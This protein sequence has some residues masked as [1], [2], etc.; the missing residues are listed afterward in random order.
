MKRNI[1]HIE[2]VIGL[3]ILLLTANKGYSQ[4][5]WMRICHP[6]DKSI[7]N[8]TV[9]C[10][11][12][13]NEYG[14]YNNF[15]DLDIN[16]DGI[17]DIQL[18]AGFQT[19]TTDI[20]CGVGI[21]AKNGCKMA[22]N[23]THLMR[24]YCG[25]TIVDTCSFFNTDK[26]YSGLAYQYLAYFPTSTYSFGG[27]W[28]GAWNHGYIAVKI[29]LE[30]DTLFG[31]LSLTVTVI[32]EWSIKA[33]ID[34][35]AYQKVDHTPVEPPEILP[36]ITEGIFL[37]YPNPVIDEMTIQ[38]KDSVNISRIT[39]MDCRGKKVQVIPV[40]GILFKIDLSG[41][42]KGIYYLEAMSTY[43]TQVIKVLKM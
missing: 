25:D 22:F 42:P 39:L 14:A 5:N 38:L 40:T 21:E 32:G 8:D 1:P 17:V 16:G 31:W 37:V 10:G 19:H 12:S 18:D 28:Y 35:Y 30:T 9:V 24:F 2:F 27:D 3:A 11:V 6:S 13:A 4:V 33:D 26:L 34:S 7:F 20:S 15:G 43:S 41:L 29:P 36:E 23:G